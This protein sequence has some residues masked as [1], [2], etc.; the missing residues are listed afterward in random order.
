MRE[1]I[2]S[3]D[4]ENRKQLRSQ[5]RQNRQQ[6]RQQFTNSLKAASGEVAQNS[7]IPVVTEQLT[8]QGEQVQIS[9]LTTRIREAMD[10]PEPQMRIEG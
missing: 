5:M 4:P 2:R 9:D 8:Y 7:G 3:N 1:N 6:F 10:L